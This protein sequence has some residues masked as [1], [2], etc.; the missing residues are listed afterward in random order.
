MDSYG[1]AM[2]RYNN[3]IFYSKKNDI[4]KFFIIYFLKDKKQKEF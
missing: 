2:S 3:D 1:Y 4:S